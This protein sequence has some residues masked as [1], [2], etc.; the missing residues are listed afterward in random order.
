MSS[1]TGCSVATSTLPS[2]R[3]LLTAYSSMLLVQTTKRQSGSGT[4]K[5]ALRSPS[6]RFWLVSGGL[7]IDWMSGE[8]LMNKVM[9]T[10][11]TWSC[12]ANGLKYTDGPSY[13]SN[14]V[15]PN[16]GFFSLIYIYIY[17]VGK[18]FTDITPTVLN[19]K[20]AIIQYTGIIE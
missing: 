2:Y 10:F 13:A 11:W 5:A 3:H 14:H 16:L 9:P 6:Y 18:I 8:P 4:F 20:R 7:A 15:Y 1:G 19:I 12:L 17:L